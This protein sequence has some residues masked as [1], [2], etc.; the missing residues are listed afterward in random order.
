MLIHWTHTETAEQ[1]HNRRFGESMRK[2]HAINQRV[3]DFI[4]GIQNSTLFTDAE[5]TKIF[6]QLKKQ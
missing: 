1:R 6:E 3:T 5:K 4:K 2:A